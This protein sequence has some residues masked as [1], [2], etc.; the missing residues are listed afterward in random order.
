MAYFFQA[1]LIL[2]SHTL[3]HCICA[4]DCCDL[5]NHGLGIFWSRFVC[6]HLRSRGSQRGCQVSA[7]QTQQQQRHVQM[8]LVTMS[9]MFKLPTQ[10]GMS[11][12]PVFSLSGSRVHLQYTLGYY[13]SVI[14]GQASVGSGFSCFLLVTGIEQQLSNSRCLGCY[15]CF[16]LSHLCH[17]S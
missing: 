8:L 17:R 12:T 4:T 14:S 10:V 15:P 11:F 5:G 1:C 6:Q 3:Q 16:K 2:V 13:C 7:V 9:S